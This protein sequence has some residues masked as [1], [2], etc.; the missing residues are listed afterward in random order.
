[1][2][3]AE[4]AVPFQPIRWLYSASVI[5]RSGLHRAMATPYHGIPCY[6]HCPKN[7]R[8]GHFFLLV[9]ID[10]PKQSFFFTSLGKFVRKP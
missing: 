7:F 1:M 2:R 9:F 6:G 8:G 3:P 10:A 4:G 5:C